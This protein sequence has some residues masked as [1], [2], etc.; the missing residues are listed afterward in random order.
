[1][2]QNAVFSDRRDT[3]SHLVQDPPPNI[4]AHPYPSSLLEWR[5]ALE[6]AKGT[7]Y[8]GGVY[9]GKVTFPADYPFKPPSVVMLTP[10]GRLAVNK[11]L[12]VSMTGFLTGKQ[13]QQAALVCLA[14]TLNTSARA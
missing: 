6:G 12:C 10:N 4:R 2:C 14:L 11:K 8:E 1:M 13:G 5:Y 9:H 3:T 7:D